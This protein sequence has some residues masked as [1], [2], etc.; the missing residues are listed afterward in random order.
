MKLDQFPRV[1]LGNLPTPLEHAPRLTAALGGPD[2]WIKRDDLTGLA[3]GGNKTR[4]LEFVLAEAL[5]QGADVV[6]TTGGPQSNHARQTAAACARLGLRCVL[7]LRGDPTVARQGNLLLD[8]LL[9]AEVR[10]LN[11]AREERAAAMAS[12]ADE[13]RLQGHRPYVIPLGASTG[14]GALGYV[15]AAQ[16]LAAQ[17][18]QAGLDVDAVIL[19]S[20]SGGTHAG[21]LVGRSLCGE[22]WPVWGISNDDARAG[23]TKAVARVAAEATSLLGMASLPDGEIIVYDEYIGPGY[24]IMTDACREAMGLVAQTEGVLLDPV[25]TGKAMAGLIGLVRQGV[26]KRGQTVVFVHTGGVPALFAYGSDL[27]LAA[28]RG[29]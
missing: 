1:R 11:I 5:T 20:S 8:D 2:I 16:E 22:S 18:R 23:L 28:G 13:L 4:K 25:Y 29:K 24:G 15:A 26:L 9:G 12:I 6:L 3:L 14:L 27:G 7:V 10:I 21:L 17:I 19:C